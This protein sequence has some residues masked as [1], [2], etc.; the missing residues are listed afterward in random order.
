MVR[1]VQ[2]VKR[3]A[4]STSKTTTSYLNHA[5]GLRFHQD[6]RRRKSQAKPHLHRNNNRNM[7]GHHSTAQVS[8]PILCVISEE[9]HH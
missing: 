6:Q 4:T 5:N 1:G 8:Q 9:I 3:S 7:W 2:Q